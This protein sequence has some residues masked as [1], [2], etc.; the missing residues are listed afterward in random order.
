MRVLAP[1]AK[2]RAG[3]IGNLILVKTS[4]KKFVL[5]LY[6]LFKTALGNNDAFQILSHICGRC[7]CENMP[8]ENE[9]L[10]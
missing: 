5:G 6:F 9:I 1:E 3:G 10:T 4:L 8:L 7:C 2:P